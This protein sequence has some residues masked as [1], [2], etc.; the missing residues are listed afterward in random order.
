VEPQIKGAIGVG[1]EAENPSTSVVGQKDGWDEVPLFFGDGLFGSILRPSRPGHSGWVY[2]S[3]FGNE[4]TNSQ[5]LGFASARALAATG[6]WV[7][8][9]DYRGTGDSRGAFFDFGVEDYL[10]DI[11]RAQKELERI[12]GTRCRGLM[13]LRLGA[14]LAAVAAAR[15]DRE[16][17]LVM[18]EPVLDGVRY[19]DS[20]LRIAIAN[21]LVHHGGHG[22]TR[23]ELRRRIT[24]GGSVAVDG[25]ELKERM[26]ESLASIDLGSLGR[27]T[28]GRVLIVKI[29]SGRGQ[30]IP[31]AFS[32]LC[33]LYSSAG[34]TR[35]ESVEEP[36]V[37]M[38]TRTYHWDLADL[39]GTTIRWMGE[40]QTARESSDAIMAIE[41]GV[42]HNWR[43]IERPVSFL[44]GEVPVR[45][46]V[47]LPVNKK[48]EEI[49]IV[50]VAAGEACR[51]AFFYPLLARSLADSGW[52]VLRFDPRGIGD[53]C[54][55]LGCSLLEEV[56]AKVEDG[57]LVTDTVA[58]MDYLEGG[59]AVRRFVLAGLC[60]GAI[61]AIRAAC[62]DGRIAGLIPLELPMRLTPRTYSHHN[63]PSSRQLPWY[64]LL[65]RMHGA[66]FFLRCRR[67]YHAAKGLRRETARRVASMLP[68]A[69][70][71][72]SGDGA[73]YRERVGA[74]ASVPMLLAFEEALDKGIPVHCVFADSEQ[75]R[76]FEAAIPGLLRGRPDASDLMTHSVIRGADHNFT[77]PGCGV[78]LTEAVL[79]WLD[80]AARPWFGE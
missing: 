63:K 56:F 25:F 27:P 60:G 5:R 10:E 24:E 43:S 79:S 51:S 8:R 19:R 31:A 32:N 22:Q 29:A 1:L 11:E 2:C 50:L 33:D 39:F 57:L 69:P 47:H 28:A 3:A 41:E 54:G 13:G 34:E 78:G 17:D 6:A 46:I 9:F 15:C 67:L 21:E 55:E 7:L 70:A 62:V 16:L 72:K 53:S 30:A 74:D 65:Q 75:P 40:S 64:E 38:R 20:L 58:A 68:S 61:T 48:R 59:E 4:R 52:I 76:L 80:D 36:P 71:R 18:W 35:L 37:W 73:W 14:S 44:V 42:K 26:F 66:S 45:G 12:S 23:D 49:A 77:M